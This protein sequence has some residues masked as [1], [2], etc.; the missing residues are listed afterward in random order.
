[1]EV[2]IWVDLDGPGFRT[3]V[4][5]F[6]DGDRTFRARLLALAAGEWTGQTGFRPLTGA[7]KKSKKIHCEG[8]LWATDNR[9][10]IVQPDGVPFF[11]VGW[12]FNVFETGHKTTFS[13]N[14]PGDGTG[15]ES[16]ISFLFNVA[17]TCSIG[18]KNA[19]MARI[20]CA[21]RLLRRGRD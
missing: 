5:G 7:G 13:A 3:R 9:H 4:F 17:G 14:P 11:M 20:G 10:A 6:W 8:V 2:A 16:S 18:N 21:K 15:V 1:V 12:V 19:L